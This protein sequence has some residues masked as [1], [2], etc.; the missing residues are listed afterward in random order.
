MIYGKGSGFTATKARDGSITITG[1]VT[2]SAADDYNW[3]DKKD[4]A[5]IPV[6]E[7][8]L[9]KYKPSDISFT[10]FN[11][12]GYVVVKDG[13]FKD[14]ASHKYGR[15]FKITSKDNP[16]VRIEFNDRLPN[17]NV[18]RLKQTATPGGSIP[19]QK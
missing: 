6:T 19:N 3:N 8:H 4:G 12:L 16:T 11:V 2:L 7:Y 15:D 18:Q 9:N 17:V 13:F 5:Q 14:L 10:G 1:N